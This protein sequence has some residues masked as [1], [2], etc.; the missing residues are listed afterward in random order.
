MNV[1]VL[2]IYIDFVIATPAEV[3][4]HYYHFLMENLDNNIICQTMLKLEL[5]TELDVMDSATMYSEYQKN[6]FLLD[7]LL[8]SDASNI[9][10]FCH[11]LQNTESKQDIGK[12]LV[13][14]KGIKYLIFI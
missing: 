13:D 9:T 6:S 2:L 1:H 14:G 4:D 12:I 11:M 8:V 5:I 10:E 3:I 7:Q